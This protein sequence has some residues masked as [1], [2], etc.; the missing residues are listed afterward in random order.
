M[1]TPL[2][3]EN[4]YTDMRNLKWSPSEKTIARKAFNLALE[5]ELEGVISETKHRAAK[6]NDPS[7]LWDLECYLHERRKEIDEKYD[8]RYSVLP[9]VFALL[10]REGRLT[11]EDLH[12]LGEDKLD[13]VRRHLKVWA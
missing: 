6:I 12:G 4:T 1:A 11:V 3:R 10:I 13:F 7:D 8:Y 2:Q 9:T 5:S